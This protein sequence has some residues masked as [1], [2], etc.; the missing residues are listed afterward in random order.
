MN[1]SW[2]DAAVLA[3]V[4]AAG[5][6]A[7]ALFAVVFVVAGIGMLA[8]LVVFVLGKKVLLGADPAVVADPESIDDPDALRWFGEYAARTP[9]ASGGA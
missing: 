7:G 3:W 5:R 9:A 2:V 6:A 8:G 4:V 1:E